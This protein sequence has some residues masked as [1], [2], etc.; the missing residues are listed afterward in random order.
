MCGA[1]ARAYLAR[2]IPLERAEL[3]AGNFVV[4]PRSRVYVGGSR[5]CNAGDIEKVEEAWVSC[6]RYPV[7]GW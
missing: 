3:A 5:V 2:F 7:M 6:A 4:W 1:Y